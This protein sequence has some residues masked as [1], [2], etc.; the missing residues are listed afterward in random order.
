MGMSEKWGLPQNAIF[1]NVN[2]EISVFITFG[3]GVHCSETT[4]IPNPH[5]KQT[6]PMYSQRNYI[7]EI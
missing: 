7:Q 3:L 4:H 6:T 2:G 5:P 1:N